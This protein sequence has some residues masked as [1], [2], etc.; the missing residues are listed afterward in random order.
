MTSQ[1]RGKKNKASGVGK[2][3]FGLT[4]RTLSQ[5]TFQV[6]KESGCERMKPSSA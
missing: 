4:Q 6:V 5:N 1:S 2:A 3:R